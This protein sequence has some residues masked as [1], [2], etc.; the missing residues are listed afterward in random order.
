M[1]IMNKK[2]IINIKCTPT[3]LSLS[4]LTV[5]LY[6]PFLQHIYIINMYIYIYEDET[7]ER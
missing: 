5:S 2:N 1:K 7:D 3:Y 4:G 6:F